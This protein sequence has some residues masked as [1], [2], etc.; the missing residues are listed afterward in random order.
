MFVFSRWSSNSR[1]RISC[2][3]SRVRIIRKKWKWFL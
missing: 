2:Y 1:W 3:S